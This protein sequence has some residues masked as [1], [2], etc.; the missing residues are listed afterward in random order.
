MIQN[1]ISWPGGAKVA[2]AITFDMDADSLIHIEKGRKGVNYL[3]TISMLR[4]GPEVAVPRILDG[5]RRYGL[6]QTFFVPAWCIEQH[7][8]AVEAIVEGGHE[9][10][11]HGYIH[12]APNAL[13]P[14]EELYWMQR[15]IEVIERFT[16]MRPRG[17]RSPLYNMSAATPG[18]LA[19]E[20]FLYDSSLMG[21]DVPYILAPPEGELVELP[22]SWATDDWP[23]YV[24]SID[25][26]YMFQVLPPDRAMEVFMAEFNAM[27]AAGG[28]LWIGVWHPFVS[29]RLSR[30]QRV[31]QMIEDMQATGEVWFA[32]LEQIASHCLAEQTR[33]AL[34]LRRQVLPLYGGASPLP[35]RPPT[36]MPDV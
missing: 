1:P 33:G 13:P 3:S 30:W 16:G 10:G 8:K 11:F 20:G 7:P 27:R 17:N 24:H 4:Y 12:E 15:S 29:G 19:D 23:P 35:P 28:G 34:E 25:L 32:T 36:S 5:Y 22:V 6:T 26:D 18:F 14:E 2:V 21:D 31:E 9:V